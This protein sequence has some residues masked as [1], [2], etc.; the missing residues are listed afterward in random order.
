V[1]DV[2][3]GSAG[4]DLQFKKTWV[5][6]GEQ[7]SWAGVALMICDMRAPFH[8]LKNCSFAPTGTTL[9]VT[10]ADTATR[11]VH[12]FDGHRAL[13]AHAAAVGLPP[14]DVD[15]NTLFAHPSA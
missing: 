5:A 15:N 4:D 12:E 2:V 10:R 6:L 3:G 13:D 7:V 11:T 8:I 9:R 1:L 14:E